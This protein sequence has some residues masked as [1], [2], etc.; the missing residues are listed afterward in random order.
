[1]F[2]I[3]LAQLSLSVSGKV[4]GDNSYMIYD[5]DGR[6][7]YEIIKEPYTKVRIDGV[8]KNIKEATDLGY[9]VEIYNDENSDYVIISQTITNKGSTEKKIDLCT[10]L[11]LKDSIDNVEASSLTNFGYYL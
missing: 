5:K 6:E 2:S 4:V 10:A 11:N 7:N 9:S 3:L 8:T 1:M